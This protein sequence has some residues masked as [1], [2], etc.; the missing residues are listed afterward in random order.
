M[1]FKVFAK[2][3]APIATVPAV[4]IQ[5][6]GLFSLNDA[7]YRMLGEPKAV[8]FLWDEDER[9]IALRPVPADH[10]NGYPARRQSLSKGTG[11]VL[12]AGSMF[13]KFID[14][15]TSLA[16]RWTPRLN[17]EGLLIIDLKVPGAVVISNRGRARSEKTAPEEG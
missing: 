14:L 8:E 4:T 12:V 2:G 5:K 15:D 10:L 17:E 13:T 9:L 7:A 3:S 6:R 11:P 16:Q 1:A